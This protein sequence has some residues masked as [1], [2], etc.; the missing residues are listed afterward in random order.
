MASR[1]VEVM[2]KVNAE[3]LEASIER[4]RRELLPFADLLP[5][6]PAWRPSFWYRTSERAE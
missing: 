2:L 1:E 6:H 4:V 5:R 3:E